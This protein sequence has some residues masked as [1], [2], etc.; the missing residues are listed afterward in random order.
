M[1]AMQ[2]S[3][4]SSTVHAKM[5]PL[6]ALH[7]L[8]LTC[9]SWPTVHH[10]TLWGS[11]A[12]GIAREEP[13]IQKKPQDGR[14]IQSGCPTGLFL[15][16]AAL[17]CLMPMSPPIPAYHLQ[18]KWPT[19]LPDKAVKAEQAPPN[20]P[21]QTSPPQGKPLPAPAQL[22]AFWVF[23]PHR[24]EISHPE[25][26]L[27]LEASVICSGRVC[28]FHPPSPHTCF[29]HQVCPHQSQGLWQMCHKY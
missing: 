3:V 29:C 16:A 11:S 8:H 12:S 27:Q 24:T 23:F 15:A 25:S 22:R 28:L 14:R 19:W 4:L 20:L 2:S 10:I 26:I 18:E 13:G 6:S 1:A 5:P 9:S 7:R 21:T 17:T